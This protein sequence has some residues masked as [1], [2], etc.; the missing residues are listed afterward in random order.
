MTLLG[1]LR[2]RW[3]LAL[4]GLLVGIALFATR[5]ASFY[6]DVLWFDSIGFSGVFWKLL[7]TRLV[8]GLV[9]GLLVTA[10]VAGNMLLARRLAPAYRIPSPQEAVVERYRQA[11]LPYVRP[12]L[13]GVA[14]L[15]GLIAGL[16]MSGRWSTYLLWANAQE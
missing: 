8:L 5:L 7:A 1:R 2:R 14:V 15:F 11:L 13:L 10:L 6:T 3:W 16:S 4:L 9:A 12:V